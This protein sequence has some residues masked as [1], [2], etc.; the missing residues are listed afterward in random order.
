MSYWDTRGYPDLIQG[1]VDDNVASPQHIA[2]WYTSDANTLL[3]SYVLRND[4]DDENDYTDPLHSQSYENNSIADFMGTSRGDYSSAGWNLNFAPNASSEQQFNE[5]GIPTIVSGMVDY[6]AYRG[7]LAYAEYIPYTDD[8]WDQFR[9]E[10]DAGRPVIFFVDLGLDGVADHSVP[11]FGY[12][13]DGADIEYYYYNLFAGFESGDWADFRVLQSGARWSIMGMNVFRPGQSEPVRSATD[14]VRSITG[15]S[16]AVSVTPGYS[17][18]NGDTLYIRSGAAVSVSGDYLAAVKGDQ[19]RLSY[20]ADNFTTQLRNYYLNYNSVVQESGSTVSAAGNYT[21][22]YAVGNGCNIDLNGVLST[23]GSYGYALMLNGSGNVIDLDQNGTITTSGSMGWGVNAD[24]H[25]NT[26]NING[27]VSTSGTWGIGVF[28]NNISDL[29]VGDSGSINTVQSNS[30]GVYAQIQNSISIKGT[31]HTQAASTHALYMITGNVADVRGRLTVDQ[32]ATSYAVYSAATTGYLKNVL[33]LRSGAV[34]NGNCRNAGLDGAAEV[35]FGGHKDIYGNVTSIDHDFDFVYS[36]RFLGSRWEGNCIGGSTYFTGGSNNFT[37]FTVY[38][39]ATLGG[40]ATLRVNNGMNNYGIIAPGNKGLGTLTIDGDIDFKA[41]SSCDLEIDTSGSSDFLVVTGALTS[42]G[43]KVRVP[44]GPIGDFAGSYSDVISAGTLAAEQYCGLYFV[45]GPLLS[46]V[47]ALDGT[48]VDINVVS[49]TFSSAAR[50]SSQKNLA[51]VFDANSGTGGDMTVVLNNLKYIETQEGIE[52]AYDD[53]CSR[54][55]LSY[56]D[57][58]TDISYTVNRE[59][60]R[61]QNSGIAQQ[62]FFNNVNDFF[63]GAGAFWAKGYKMMGDAESSS[64]RS[65]YDYNGETFIFGTDLEPD[66]FTRAGLAYAKGKIYTDYSN[67]DAGDIT[68]D[69]Y[70]LY[71]SIDK[72]EIF[73]DI[74]ITYAEND[75]KSY[76]RLRFADIDR[77]AFASYRTGTLD[78]YLKHGKYFSLGKTLRLGPSVSIRYSYV[79]FPSYEEEGAGALDLDVDDR[80]EQKLE[81]GLGTSLKKNFSFKSFE[82]SFFELHGVWYHQT[83]DNVSE[84]KGSFSSI[85]GDVLRY[86]SA[87]QSRNRY[88]FGIDLLLGKSRGWSFG[89]EY[90]M[91]VQRDSQSHSFGMKIRHDF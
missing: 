35:N 22:A 4:A 59:V 9:A 19:E 56:S 21:P 33:N 32:T 69:A 14:A 17:G 77:I 43:G 48:T 23:S 5:E 71:C 67:G 80:Q 10:I 36:N 3:N 29:T 61:K 25:G 58:L 18:A 86:S 20:F 1:N 49:K 28:L 13:Y 66:A 60:L 87:G 68:F 52:N 53:I 41:G 78:C 55:A 26:I 2:A 11:C 45:S 82:E 39:G 50:T 30:H 79:R 84:F 62:M 74:I 38:N 24:G 88:M 34:L 75:N 27:T 63:A 83:M 81:L 46:V 54:T 85:D 12:R 73:T 7:C 89:L 65:G 31:I 64:S 42:S 40:T 16:G 72:D 44:A 57:I 37:N 6:A 51:A 90:D 47:P 91:L 15:A 70:S 8:L 76:R